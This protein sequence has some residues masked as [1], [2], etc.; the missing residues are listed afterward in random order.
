[1]AETLES[2][3]Q[4]A[5]AA[6][7]PLYN[8]F[9]HPLPTPQS[10]DRINQ[11]FGIQLPLQLVESVRSWHHS[12]TW[13]ASLGPDYASCHHIIRIN[14]YWRRRRRTRRLP[15]HLIIINLGYDEDFDC[16]D[17]NSPDAESGGYM[18]QYWSPGIREI[19]HQTFLAYLAQQIGANK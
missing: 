16:L 6:P 13:F 9:Q 5:N 15:N 3:I 8:P 10:I 2:L 1:M 17:I 11:H 14:R 7:P 12:G 4:Y 18:I 19:T